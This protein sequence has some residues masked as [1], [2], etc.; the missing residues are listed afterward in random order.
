M[1]HRKLVILT[2]TLSLLISFTAFIT[3][4]SAD[5]DGSIAVQICDWY[6]QTTDPRYETYYDDVEH[7]RGPT[8]SYVSFYYIDVE[9]WPITSTEIDV[10]DLLRKG[11]SADIVILDA[12]EGY[13]VDESTFSYDPE[14]GKVSLHIEVTDQDHGI[15]YFR[16]FFTDDDTRV[17]IFRRLPRVRS[18]TWDSGENRRIL[19]AISP[20]TVKSRRTLA[21]LV[22]QVYV[23]TES[24]T[25]PSLSKAWPEETDFIEFQG[26][27]AASKA[28]WWYIGDEDTL[29]GAYP[30]KK[31]RRPCITLWDVPDEPTQIFTSVFIRY[32]GN[33]KDVPRIFRERVEP[34]VEYDG[35]EDVLLGWE[36]HRLSGNWPWLHREGLVRSLYNINVYESFD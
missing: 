14:T 21:Y 17:D 11:L 30:F 13:D 31:Y 10:H 3:Q 6:S 1:R 22:K 34:T 26:D 35:E 16:L 7:D 5:L 19:N 4:T 25:T 24:P 36:S 18:T 27:N 20:F 2:L 32:L 33:G 29:E 9:W 8:Y 15:V 28:S 23:Q 12:S